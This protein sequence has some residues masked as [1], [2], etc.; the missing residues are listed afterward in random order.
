MASLVLTKH[1]KRPRDFVRDGKLVIDTPEEFCG[2]GLKTAA[3]AGRTSQE[4]SA[5]RPLGPQGGQN[6]RYLSHLDARAPRFL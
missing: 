6:L 5:A 1:P 3:R 4:D 2:A